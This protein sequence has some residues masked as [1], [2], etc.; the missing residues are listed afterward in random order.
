MWKYSILEID[1]DDTLIKKIKKYSKIG[2]VVFLLLGLVGMIFPTVMTLGTLAFVSYLMLFAGV[3]AGVLTWMS[4]RKDWTGWLKSFIL[5]AVA[6]YMI[7][8]PLDGVATLGLL[9]SFYFLM[10]AFSSTGLAFSA[11]GKKH[12]WVWIFNASTSFVMAVIFLLNWPFSSLWLIGF[13][14]GVSLFFDGIALL[15]GGRALDA[16]EEKDP[17]KEKI[18]DEK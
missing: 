7:F 5:I 1:L 2:G 18:K 14:V 3:S 6:L 11:E 8:F 16:V 9:F 13:F 10:D 12:R 17:V 15:V 4:N